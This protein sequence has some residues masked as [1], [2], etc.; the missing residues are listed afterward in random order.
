MAAFFA[1]FCNFLLTI[2]LCL[3]NI[4]TKHARKSTKHTNFYTSK[5]KYAT[6]YSRNQKRRKEVKLMGKTFGKMVAKAVTL[7]AKAAC[8]S[9]SL[10]GFY[11]PAAPKSMKSAK[12]SEKK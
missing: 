7:S 1:S 11:Q 3:V 6:I 12:K 5:E 2:S 4:I 8:N 10:V 9:T